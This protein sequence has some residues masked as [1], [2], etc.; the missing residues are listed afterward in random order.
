MRRFVFVLLAALLLAVPAAAQ[1]TNYFQGDQ[2]T[3]PRTEIGAAFVGYNNLPWS[4]PGIG[5]DEY[6]WHGWIE[7]TPDSLTLQFD[8]VYVV[9]GGDC[10]FLVAA[11]REWRAGK[12]F[13]W[14]GGLD[15]YVIWYPDPA[16]PTSLEFELVSVQVAEG[17]ADLFDGAL[18]YT[19][20]PPIWWEYDPRFWLMQWRIEPFQYEVINMPAQA[21][22]E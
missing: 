15:A 20:A 21:Q 14:T 11:P 19:G 16:N 6:G 1:Y 13:S 2:V 8:M 9:S 18:R 3:L 5:W 4:I 17:H 7:A 10:R 12:V 22:V